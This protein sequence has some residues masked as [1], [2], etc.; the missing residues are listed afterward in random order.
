MRW[1]AES[2]QFSKRDTQRQKATT[3]WLILRWFHPST[4]PAFLLHS[5]SALTTHLIWQTCAVLKQGATTDCGTA[6][7]A[8]GEAQ[9]KAE[10]E[11]VTASAAGDV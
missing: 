3:T 6:G 4:L 2:A 8:A 1:R 10:A 9:A 11:A 5:L 7:E